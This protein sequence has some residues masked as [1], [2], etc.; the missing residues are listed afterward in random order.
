MCVGG[1]SATAVHDDASTFLE[2]HYCVVGP[3]LCSETSFIPPL[4][5]YYRSEKW[6]KLKESKNKTSILHC[7]SDVKPDREN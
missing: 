6:L 1:F 5:G 4:A 7:H 2:P 3:L